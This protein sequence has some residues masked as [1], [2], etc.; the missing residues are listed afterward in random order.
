M[1]IVQ[2]RCV[3]LLCAELG[4]TEA[5]HAG[6]PPH[7]GARR[8]Q[9]QCCCAGKQGVRLWKNCA[10]ARSML[11]VPAGQP[12]AS[13]GVSP[14]GSVHRS[15]SVPAV[16]RQAAWEAPPWP[17][18]LADRSPPPPLLA[19][20]RDCPRCVALH[21]SACSA[22]SR[23]LCRL[24]RLFGRLCLLLPRAALHL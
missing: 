18:Q 24:C 5:L 23:L 15:L 9:K 22:P 4:S 14:S 20:R 11:G 19:I 2:L 8:E 17:C 10:V 21:K 13:Q 7:G 6:A 3:V 16:H 1:V 12:F